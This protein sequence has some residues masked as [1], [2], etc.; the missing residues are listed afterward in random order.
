MFKSATKTLNIVQK[1]FHFFKSK[2]FLLYGTKIYM[3]PFQL[4][5]DE[6]LFLFSYFMR[7]IAH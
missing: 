1:N 5:F 4:N 2:V 7:K 3:L 6:N